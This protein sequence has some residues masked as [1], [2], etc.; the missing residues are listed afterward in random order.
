MAQMLL[1]SAMQ[2]KTDLQLNATLP[3]GTDTAKAQ[4][5]VEIKKWQKSATMSSAFGTEKAKAQ[6]Q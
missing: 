5:T 4:D 2:K 1:E 3:T 6:N